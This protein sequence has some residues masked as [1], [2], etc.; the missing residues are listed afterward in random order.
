MLSMTT[1][2][3]SENDPA[4]AAEIQAAHDQIVPILIGEAPNPF[5]E[6][7]SNLLK[8]TVDT[9]CWVLQHEHSEGFSEKL[10]R[11]DEVF[12]SHG[13]VTFTTERPRQ[14]FVTRAAGLDS[15]LGG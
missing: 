7:H 1:E 11:I 5:D 3:H 13:I 6:E 10:L 9:L 2:P 14:A 4:A 15:E 8:A 12:T